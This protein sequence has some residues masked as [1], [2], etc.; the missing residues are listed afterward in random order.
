MSQMLK[1]NGK[2]LTS[3]FTVALTQLVSRQHTKADGAAYYIDADDEYEFE[4][5]S[6]VSDLFVSLQDCFSFKVSLLVIRPNQEFKIR[7]EQELTERWAISKLD[8][9]SW[10]TCHFSE[11]EQ[12]W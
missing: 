4:A 10:N 7:Y 3:V 5:M 11:S 2:R 12:W 1:A 9:A 8:G 6:E